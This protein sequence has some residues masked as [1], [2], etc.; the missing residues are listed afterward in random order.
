MVLIFICL[1]SLWSNWWKGF[2][3]RLPSF[4]DLHS[5]SLWSIL[6]EDIW[7]LLNMYSM[8]C[9]TCCSIVEKKCFI[10]EQ[11][12]WRGLFILPWVQAGLHLAVLYYPEHLAVLEV[13]INKCQRSAQVI[14]PVQC[15]RRWSWQKN[16]I[17]LTGGPCS[18][19]PVGPG[20]PGWPW[21]PMSPC[22]LSRDYV[23]QNKT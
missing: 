8:S 3:P 11:L 23:E 18:P 12:C 4:P 9:V 20:G 16:N 19:I 7:S 21:N 17:E 2:F 13:P 15:K 10:C 6:K 5:S 1:C 14:E 22:R